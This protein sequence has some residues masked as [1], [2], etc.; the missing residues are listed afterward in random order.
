MKPF[1]RVYICLTGDL[2]TDYR[3]HKTALTLNNMGFKVTCVSRMKKGYSRSPQKHC[4]SKILPTLFKKGPFFY[5][6]YNLRLFLY[7]LTRKRAVILS[8]DL[9]TL[10]GCTIAARLR[11]LPLVFDSHEY[12]PEVPELQHRPR[13]KTIWQKLEKWLIPG[14]DHSY[15][16]CESIAEIYRRKYKTNMGVVRNLPLYSRMEVQADAF[17]D[18]RFKL[19]YQGALNMGRGLR[20]IIQS[21]TLL[22]ED[23]LLIIVGDGDEMKQLKK[24]VI[25]LHLENKVLFI[26]KIPHHQLAYYTLGADVG[27]CLL[28]N[29]GLNYYF[30]LPNRVFDYAQ[31]GVP[32]L[33]TGFPEIRRVVEHYNTGLLIDDLQSETIAE[34]IRQLKS[35]RMLREQLADN[36]RE[37]AKILCWEN[38]EPQLKSY[39]EEYLHSK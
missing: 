11:R 12:F 32:I 31:A 18:T 7:L 34:A 30:S 36:G 33:A 9:D 19:L 35:N 10:T 17:S 29:I 27:L 6:E 20:Q 8:I 1:K 4:A 16:V 3:V 22:D 28:E 14:A 2:S 23:T 25:D 39:F 13:V 38:E 24:Q 37:A 26:G 21:M 5:A 15:T